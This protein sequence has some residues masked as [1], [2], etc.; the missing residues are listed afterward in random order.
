MA[1]AARECKSLRFGVQVKDV[2]AAW[3]IRFDVAKG[4][5]AAGVVTFLDALIKPL[6]T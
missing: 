2:S 4:K 1:V 5:M 3:S 6:A